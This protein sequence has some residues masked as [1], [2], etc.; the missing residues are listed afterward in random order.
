MSSLARS[1][2]VAALANAASLCLASWLLGGFDVRLGGFVVAVALFTVLAVALRR[3]T[4]SLA[5]RAV[6]PSAVVGGLVVTAAALAGT[7][8]LVPHGGFDLEGPWTWVA[9]ILIV[10]AAGVAYGE[11]DTQAPADVP[12]V[13]A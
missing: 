12:P 11:V 13:E 7:D 8:A 3:A 1:V 10:W 9:V 4:A 2:L 6:R 5:P